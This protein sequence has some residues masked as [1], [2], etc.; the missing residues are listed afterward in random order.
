[1]PLLSLGE[2]SSIEVASLW[3]RL[4]EDARFIQSDYFSASA[5]G[6]PMADVQQQDA[7]PNFAVI[8]ASV[9][10]IDWLQLSSEGL[11]C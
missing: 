6:Q 2:Q 3:Q 8:S 1:M 4:I 9:Q 11:C 10:T 7:T 5:P